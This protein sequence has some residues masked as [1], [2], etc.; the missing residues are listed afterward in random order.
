ML[1]VDSLC[2]FSLV[3]ILHFPMQNFFVVATPSSLVS[4]PDLYSPIKKVASNGRVVGLR[5]RLPSR[6]TRSKRQASGDSVWGN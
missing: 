5:T 2:S 6:M 4:F 1:F 3:K